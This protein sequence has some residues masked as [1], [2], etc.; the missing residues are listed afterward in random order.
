[1]IIEKSISYMT[2]EPLW[3]FKKAKSAELDTFFKENW[4]ENFELAIFDVE[5]QKCMQITCSAYDIKEI[6]LKVSSELNSDIEF[7]GVNS[8]TECYV[9]GLDLHNQKK[10]PLGLYTYE[11]K[12]LK[13]VHTL[14]NYKKNN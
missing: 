7:I 10:Y 5:S 9:S 2:N 1:M 11:N 3:R 8:L 12:E 14:D 13:L 4:H 6:L